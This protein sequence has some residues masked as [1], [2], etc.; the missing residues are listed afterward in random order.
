MRRKGTAIILGLLLLVGIGIR[1]HG[2]DRQNQS[3]EVPAK[4]VLVPLAEGFEDTEAIPVISILRRAGAMVT[5]ASLGETTVTSARG[6]R[7][8]ADRRMDDCAG[9]EYDLIVLPG[10]MPAATYL[11][12]S[13]ILKQMLIRQNRLG[14]LYAAICASPAVVLEAHGLLAGKRATCYPS[15]AETM[16]D[17]FTL[18]QRVVM[19]QNCITSQGPGTSMEFALALVEAL[20]GGDK[21]AALKKGYLVK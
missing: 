11:H 16:P 1:A 5:V 3:P 21:A 10:G 18:D 13:E 8:I 4:T 17:K 7:V 20:Y 6:V 12:D 19:D 2:E 15:V 14:K 9:D